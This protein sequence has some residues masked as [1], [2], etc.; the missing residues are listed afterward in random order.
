MPL[1]ISKRTRKTKKKPSDMSW[2]INSVLASIR[3]SALDIYIEMS[4][5]ANTAMCAGYLR[6]FLNSAMAI[7]HK[8]FEGGQ[9]SVR[10][11]FNGTEKFEIFCILSVKP[12]QI[13]IEYLKKRG[14]KHAPYREFVADDYERA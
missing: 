4:D 8:N 6:I 13:I 5:A 7:L 9:L 10:P 2:L 12:A 14:R 1:K 3:I 11:G